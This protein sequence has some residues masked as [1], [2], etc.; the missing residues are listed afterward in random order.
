MADYH[1]DEPVVRRGIDL[2][3]RDIKPYLT[4]AL[5]AVN[6]LIWGVM[7]L[8]GRSRGVGGSED[9]EVLLDF[10][11]MF[12]PLI[13][14]G[15]YWRLFS[16]MFLHVGFM[17][18]LFNGIGLLIF[19]RLVE[20]ALGHYRFALVYVLAGLSGS[21]ASFLLNSVAIG[22]GASGAI[23]GVLGALVA[24][25]VVNRGVLGEMGRQT[26]TALL[27]LG[28]INLFFGFATPGIDNWAH[29]GG[30]VAGFGLGMALTPKYQLT[31][32]PFGMDRELVDVDSHARYWWAVPLV[33]V[34]LIAGTWLATVTMVDNPLT[35]IHK[36]ERLFDQES[37]RDALDEIDRSIRLDTTIGRAHY[38][39]GRILAEFGNLDAARFE[40]GL[41]IRLGLDT[42]TRRDAIALLLALNP[43]R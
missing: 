11:A 3:G 39:R 14:D 27:V 24:F 16:A 19:G 10:G 20:R 13:A 31:S 41:A 42:R 28:A 23:F 7:E 29:I 37:Y 34:L 38:V 26:L 15:E 32:G 33:G 12:G 18:L 22:A 9:P 43:R 6:V 36:A 2:P 8:T 25:L 21:V 30:L 17:H 1:Q 40:L 5:L 4:W 35:R